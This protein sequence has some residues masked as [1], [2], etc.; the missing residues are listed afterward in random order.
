MPFC[1]NPIQ[2]LLIYAKGSGILLDSWEVKLHLHWNSTCSYSR[3]LEGW[4]RR[5]FGK[6]IHHQWWKQLW[7]QTL[8]N[9]FSYYHHQQFPD[10]LIQIF[11]ITAALA[12]FIL[13]LLPRSCYPL[14]SHHHSGHTSKSHPSP[15]LY[16]E[17]G[18]G[19]SMIYTPWEVKYVFC[20][21]VMYMTER[22]YNLG[23][24]NN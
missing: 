18:I 4:M 2:S 17:N 13:F 6:L 20:M 21:C 7:I 22:Q 8:I 9:R 12:H 3:E 16:R 24:C 23:N 10:L 19:D 5:A 15:L 14:C 1:P 11:S